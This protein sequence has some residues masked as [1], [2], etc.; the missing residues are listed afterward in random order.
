M[1]SGF[2]ELL[3][4]PGFTKHFRNRHLA[5]LAVCVQGKL[6]F[7]DIDGNKRPQ[8]LPE[9]AQAKLLTQSNTVYEW[10]VF[11]PESTDPTAVPSMPEENDKQTGNDRVRES[12]K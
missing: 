4:H 7:R 8:I 10:S 12:A 1:L 2:N 11:V 3:L 5:W 6:A 9:Y